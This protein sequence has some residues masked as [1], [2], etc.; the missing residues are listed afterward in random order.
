[1]SWFALLFAARM[2]IGLVFYGVS[3]PLSRFATPRPGVEGENLMAE[4]R[5]FA[6]DPQF[7]GDPWCHDYRI[8][9][10]EQRAHPC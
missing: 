7:T 5:T 3:E 8:V 6:P 2:G 9:A 4:R 10:D 1:M